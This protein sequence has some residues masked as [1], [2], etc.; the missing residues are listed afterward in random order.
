MRALKF[1]L[2]ALATSAVLGFSAAQ[3]EP[4][5]IRFGWVAPVA[6]WITM[7]PH[8]KELAKHWGKS[9]TV[10]TLRFKGT[11]PIIT[12]LATDQ[13]DIG[14]LAYSSFALAVENANMTD[15]RVIA[16]EFQDGVKGYHTNH[17]AVLKDGPIKKIEDLKGKVVA[18]N[19]I[20]AAVD[21]ACR[22]MLKRHGLEANRDY[23][24]VE[25]PF[26]T[27]LAML[28]EHKA[29]I[30]PAIPPFSF[31]PE[32]KKISRP[33]FTSRD[34]LGVSQFIVWTARKPFLDKNRAAL[35]DFMEDMMTIE[36]WFL[37]PK[38]H[39]EAAK[40]AASVVKSKPERFGWLYTKDDYYRSRDMKPNLDALQS[41]IDMTHDLGFLKAKLDARKYTDLGLVEAAAK[42]MK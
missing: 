25:A 32:M 7:I 15:L 2:A 11:P 28:K 42:R 24:L 29:D 12:A 35:V 36:H 22:A 14:D 4:V 27:M 1:T 31:N 18:T 21:I 10:E 37:D 17:F 19:A 34:S 13:I 6:N 9:Y 26:P 39:A 20:G 3:A 41:N 33:L 30:V 23:T 38:N 16:D 8:K 5:K 40:I